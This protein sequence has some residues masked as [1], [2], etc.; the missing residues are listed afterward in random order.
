MQG[1]ASKLLG[2]QRGQKI[3]WGGRNNVNSSTTSLLYVLES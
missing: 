1:R 2:N 3:Q